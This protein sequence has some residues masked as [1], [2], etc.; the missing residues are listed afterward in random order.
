MKWCLLFA[1]ICNSLMTYDVEHLFIDLFAIC[2]SSW[3]RYMFRYLP[4]LW[5]LDICS[6]LREFR[7]FSGC[8]EYQLIIKHAFCKDF[9][10]TDCLSPS[11]PTSII[12]RAENF[13]FKE[14]ELINF[15]LM[16]CGCWCSIW[17]VVTKPQHHLDFFSMV[18]PWNFIVSCFTYKP[19]IHLDVVFWKLD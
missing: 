4:Y 7:K 1:L 2:V 10:Q 18:S 17:K 13:T 8:F 9:L 12:H 11:F 14:V 6:L 19:M 5:G 3:V 16:D 15:S